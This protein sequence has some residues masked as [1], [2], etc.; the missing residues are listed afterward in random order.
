MFTQK[1]HANYVCE[2]IIMCFN[3]WGLR[4]CYL[5][6]CSGRDG[7]LGI[8]RRGLFCCSDFSFEGFRFR[9]YQFIFSFEMSYLFC[10]VFDFSIF[11]PKISQ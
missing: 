7:I 6:V 1:N 8:H 4:T 10:K 5:F 11:F 9:F 2:R 3:I